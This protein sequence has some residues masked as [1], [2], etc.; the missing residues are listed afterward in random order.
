MA[1]AT[2][3]IV[4]QDVAP[5]PAEIGDPGK[6]TEPVGAAREPGDRQ[7]SRRTSARP[8]TRRAG[9]TPPVSSRWAT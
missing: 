9:R 1:K 3:Q 5:D 4:T 2:N 8:A 6:Y 7:A